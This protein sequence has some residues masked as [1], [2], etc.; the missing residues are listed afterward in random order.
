MFLAD[1]IGTVVSPVQI[2]ILDGARCSLLR[3][4]PPDGAADRQDAHRDRPRAG[5]RR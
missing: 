5:R 3:P 4:V 2:P 1:V